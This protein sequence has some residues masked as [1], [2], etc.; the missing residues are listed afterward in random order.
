VASFDAAMVA[1]GSVA[2]LKINNVVMPN[3]VSYSG[4]NI[5]QINGRWFQIDQNSYNAIMQAESGQPTTVDVAPVNP[6]NSDLTKK[7]NDLMTS[8]NVFSG[9]K[10][11][12][13]E[14][15][16]GQD[17]YH[18]SAVISKDKLKDLM[19]KVMALIAQYQS[20]AQ[21]SA[22]SPTSV[23][24]AAPG[25][26]PAPITD[27]PGLVQNMAQAFVGSFIDTIGDINVELWIGKKDYMLYQY[28][29]DKLADLSKS[30]GAA[31][32]IEIKFNST[33][34]NFNQPIK[35]QTP[36]GVQ[37]IEEVLLPILKTQKISS[38]LSQAATEAE[39]LFAVN[40]NY[41]LLCKNGFLNGSKA[42]PYGL[43]FINVANSVIKAG[44]KNPRCF[45]ATNNFCVSTQL[46]DGTYLC[47]GNGA[48]MGTANC[49]SAL[50]ICK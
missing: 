23:S 49:I 10:Q 22:Q 45:G 3:G 12:N 47:V 28:K 4:I 44:A 40:K 41:Y 50:T 5:A 15:I 17:T 36:E 42:T 27:T 39:S 6:D 38:S 25:A 29:F 21:Q 43:T 20:K 19:N 26:T 33:S 9:A 30:L 14:V 24:T 48:T 32:S 1:V 16:S 11:I 37:K 7:I 35:V 13:S 31:T 18:Y 34:S 46:S 2:Y 8:E